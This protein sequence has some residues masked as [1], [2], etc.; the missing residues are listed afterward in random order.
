[1]DTRPTYDDLLET[2]ARLETI[3][4]AQAARIAELERRLGLNSTN[5]SK[6]PSSGGLGRPPRVQNLRAKTGKSSGGQ[7]GHKGETLAQVE[8]PDE[9]IEHAPEKCPSCGKSLKNEPVSGFE[10]RQVFDIPPPQILVT[11]H[12]A[13]VKTCSCGCAAKG[14]F[15][16]GVTAPVQYGERIS[17]AA[18]YLSAAQFIPEERLQ[19]T[20]RDLFGVTPA[21]ATLA[22]MTQEAAA[23]VD[24]IVKQIKASVAAS[25]VKHLDETGFRIGGKTRWMHVSS[26]QTLTHYRPDEKRGS[27]PVS[28]TGVAVHDHWKPYYKLENVMHALCNAHYL[29]ELKAL[30]EI[31]KEDWSRQMFR[32]LRFLSW[33]VRREEKPVDAGFSARAE[34]IYD[35]IVTAGITFHEAQSPLGEAPKRGRR[36]RR[37][38]HNLLI[39]LRDF[40]ADVLRFLN[41]PVV[42]FTNNQAERD[43]RMV[44]LKQKISGGFRTMDS[45]KNFAK[46]RSLISTAKKQNLNPLTALLNPNLIAVAG[47]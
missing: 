21:T 22:T 42:P 31:E 23:R 28:L 33:R 29:R 12:R 6:P 20:L 19:E 8:H 35:R 24:A 16:A 30:I 17:A 2:I 25:A 36:K 9:V 1:M 7:K 14:E 10:T 3:I 11:E 4:L 44:K 41:D 13:L 32:L 34:Q 46:L 38:G 15:P 47:E 40:K 18:V 5:S 27:L 43:L 26:T 45:A 37:V 39:R